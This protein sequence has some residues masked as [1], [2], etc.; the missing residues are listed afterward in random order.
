MVNRSP[1]T[2]YIVKKR[3]KDIVRSEEYHMIQ[4]FSMMTIL[5]SLGV[6]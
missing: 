2:V 3:R 4:G 1:Q 5:N 6:R